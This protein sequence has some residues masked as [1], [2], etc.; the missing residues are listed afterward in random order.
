MIP[1]QYAFL[2]A[3]PPIMAAAWF[4]GGRIERTTTGVVMIAIAFSGLLDGWRIGRSQT[5]AAL[6]DTVLFLAL[7]YL[8]LT[9]DRWWL[10]VVAA[11]QGLVVMTHLALVLRPDLTS[12]E[13]LAAVNVFYLLGLLGLLGGVLER[14]LAGEEPAGPGRRVPRKGVVAEA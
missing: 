1:I 9:R 7:L 12:M 10:M 11:T 4:K 6:C 14:W 8:A 13:N 2:L 3:L 5:G